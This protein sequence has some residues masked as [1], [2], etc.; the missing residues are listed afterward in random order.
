MSD[1]ARGFERHLQTLML[2]V[3]TG[4]LVWVGQTLIS[5]DKRTAVLESKLQD[6]TERL[7]LMQPASEARRDVADITRRLDA[8]ERRLDTMQGKTDTAGQRR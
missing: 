8:V 3:V 2:A 6:A 5:V 4:L 7:S 1:D